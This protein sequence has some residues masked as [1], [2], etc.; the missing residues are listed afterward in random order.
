M[1]KM[2]GAIVEQTTGTPIPALGH[3]GLNVSDLN[4]SREFYQAIFGLRS[5]GG[6][7]T[8]AHRYAFL[9]DGQQVTITL[10]QQS[11]GRFSPQAPGL[12]HLALALP[13]VG[14]LERLEQILRARQVPIFYE[15]IVPHAEGGDSAALYFEDPD[16]LRI[17]V[18]TPHG[19]AG[20]AAVA[21]A[22]PAC[23]FF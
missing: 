20:R 1:D 19:G 8:G 16:G 10:W 14:D 17:E 23:G 21:G 4:R 18:F 3:I 13:E 11:S 7:D 12:H 6:A 2:K 22:A 15:G 5:M 9:G